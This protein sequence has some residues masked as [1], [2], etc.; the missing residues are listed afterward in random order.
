ME[1]VELMIIVE[2]TKNVLIIVNVLNVQRDLIAK[3]ASHV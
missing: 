2:D 1:G 3:V